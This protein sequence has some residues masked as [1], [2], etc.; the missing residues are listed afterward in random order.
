MH[1]L[2]NG[3]PL[4]SVRRTRRNPLRL[5][6]RITVLCFPQGDSG[7]G[8]F[9][10]N[11]NLDWRVIGIVSFGFKCATEIPGVY[12]NVSAFLDWIR[13]NAR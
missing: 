8:L 12:T 11:N 3:V 5:F 2:T 7:G 4:T 6:A 1:P 13:E 10:P 9:L